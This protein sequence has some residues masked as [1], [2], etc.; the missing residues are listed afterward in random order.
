LNSFLQGAAGEI[1]RRLRGER[2]QEAPESRQSP[3]DLGR[4]AKQAE[5]GGYHALATGMMVLAK[6]APVKAAFE[7]F[8][9]PETLSHARKSQARYDGTALLAGRRAGQEVPLNK[10]IS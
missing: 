6:R 10:A 2:K 1:E 9:P 4:L 8:Y 3:Q 5:A 7:A